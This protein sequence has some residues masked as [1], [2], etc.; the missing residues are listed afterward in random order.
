MVSYARQ[1][2]KISFEC[3]DMPLRSVLT[4]LEEKSGLNFIFND[5]IIDGGAKVSCSIKESSVKNILVRVLKGTDIS[6]KFFDSNS[7][8]LFR[9]RDNV[10]T[11]Y[12]AKVIQQKIPVPDTVH[13]FTN[14][15]MLPDVNPKYPLGAVFNKT[16]GKVTIRLFVNTQGI[17][18]KAVIEHSSKSAVLDSASLDYAYRQR[19]IPAKADGRPVNSWY[20]ITFLYSVTDSK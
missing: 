6:F 13:S 17:V 20:I 2:G 7:V 15:E 3:K 18:S 14:A 19:F 9:D 10:K 16:E 5:N 1:G 12:S 11:R 8:V 4:V